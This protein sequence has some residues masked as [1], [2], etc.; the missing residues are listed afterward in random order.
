VAESAEA[1]TEL[2]ARSWMQLGVAASLSTICPA[3]LAG[4]STR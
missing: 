4:T 1:E 3:L 2:P